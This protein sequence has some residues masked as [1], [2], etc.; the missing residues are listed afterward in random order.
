MKDLYAKYTS[1]DLWCIKENEFQKS[2][3]N[4]RESQ[5]CIGNGFCAT[6]GVCEEIP[7]GARP[8]TYLAGLFD[9]MTAQVAELVNF[10]NPF[11]VKFTVNGEKLGVVSMDV[12]Q[13]DRALNMHDGLLMRRT[14]YSD[15]RKRRYSYQSL[16]FLSMA[17]KNM[18][19]MQVALTALDAD[20]TAELQTGVDTSVY[21]SGVVTEGNKKHFRV[22][23][24]AQENN[25]SFLSVQTYE[26]KHIVIYRSGFYYTDGG[27]KIFSDDNIIRLKLKKKRT[28]ILTIVFTV[29]ALGYDAQEYKKMKALSKKEFSKVFRLQFQNHLN[30]HIRFWRDLWTI[31]DVKIEG[32]A[33]IQKNLRFNIYH[34]IICG[35]WDK[36]LS[37]IGA[38]TLSGEGYRGHVFWDTEIFM[39]PFYAAVM[40]D[41]AKNMLI[42]RYKR[43]EKARQIALENGYRGAMFP[44]ESADSGVD[45]TPQWA[46][47]LDGKIIKIKTNQLEQHITADIAYAC[48]HYFLMTADQEFM[49]GMG[50][51]I[52]VEAARFWASRVEQ[53]KSRKYEIRDVIGPDEFHIHVNNNAYTNL[54]A[55]WNL[56]T[57]YKLAGDIQK[58]D[59]RHWRKIKDKINITKKEIA[60]WKHIAPRIV[61]NI[62]KDKVIEQFDGFF[63]KKHIEI[64]NFD[65]NFLPLL[66]DG[67]QV[68]D[69]NK[70]QFVKQ[71]DVL[72][73]L[74]LLGDYFSFKT[75][76]SNFYYYVDRTLHKSSLSPA[77]HC[78]M[79]LDVSSMGR[80]YQFFNVSLRADTSNLHGNTHEGVHAASLGGTWQAVVNGFAGI[81]IK[82]GILSISPRMPKTWG[83]IK[84]AYHF[85]GQLYKIETQNHQVK[86]R[87]CGKR[88]RKVKILA[89]GKLR[90]V[91]SN[92][93]YVFKRVR[94]CKSQRNSY[95]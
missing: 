89:F 58:D 47:D 8:G 20:A 63:K 16:R 5:F 82:N 22:K 30:Q 94:V 43:L 57:A 10:P 25:S 62:R 49:F 87:I 42:Y 46:K 80:A 65:E 6:R 34:M 64:I 67:I 21:N 70:T 1:D 69:Y 59:P 9:H 61:C 3:Q 93:D 13:H 32:T 88:K 26:K 37:S 51:E 53:N 50:Y 38:R 39:L 44:W 73:V 78:L 72:M 28:L 52:I 14:I 35:H 29:H 18:G 95:L 76:Q 54:M 91:S 7:P 17:R 55:K 86:I 60:R 83:R 79:A 15:S 85:L 12:N 56:L 33:N 31:A 45:E 2:L 74:Y 68:Q 19:V 48:H 36:G 90:T 84:C 23:E 4:V 92:R 24:I 77:I 81:Q 41:V 11:H 75:K 66:P 40:P 71:A 27:K